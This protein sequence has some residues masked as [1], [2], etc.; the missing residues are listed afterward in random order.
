MRRSQKK[1]KLL[2]IQLESTIKKKWPLPELHV[3]LFKT[4]TW[5][6]GDEN[7][8]GV[9]LVMLRDLNTVIDKV[10]FWQV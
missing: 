5:S 10:I 3:T 6:S 2:R 7:N 8:I 1:S 4:K 9:I